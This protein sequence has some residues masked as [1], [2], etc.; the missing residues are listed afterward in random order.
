MPDVSRTVL[1]PACRLDP[2]AYRGVVGTAISGIDNLP[3]NC[4]K[5]L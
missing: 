5:I 4:H 3:A 2:D 1:D